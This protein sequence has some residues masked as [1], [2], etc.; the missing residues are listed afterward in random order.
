MVFLHFGLLDH[1]N[2]PIRLLDFSQPCSE[3][4]R[5][6]LFDDRCGRNLITTGAFRNM[7]SR[8]KIQLVGRTC[9]R[10]GSGLVC[11]YFSLT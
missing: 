10:Q 1:G 8:G 7:Y 3:N 9:K 6:G 5:L 11:T 2:W 4:I